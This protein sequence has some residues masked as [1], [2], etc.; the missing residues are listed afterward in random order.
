MKNIVIL[1]LLLSGMSLTAQQKTEGY[2][3]Y[4][5]KEC[6]PSI[7]RFFSQIEHKDSLWYRKDYFIREKKLQMQGAFH[8]KACKIGEGDFF[9]YHANGVL[10][11]TGKYVKGKKQGLWI[12][13]HPNKMMHDSIL[14]ENG[15]PIGTALSWHSNGYPEDSTVYGPEGMAT[16]VSWF[17]NGNVSSA[18]RLLNGKP[19]GTWQYFHSNGILS[20]KEVYEHG[21]L[22]A[23]NYFLEDGKAKNDTSSIDREAAFPGGL[24]GWAKYLSDH[25]DFPEGYK[26]THGDKAIVV[27]DATIGEDGTVNDVTVSV[28]FY[29]AFDRMAEIAMKKSPKWMPAID[30]NRKVK[31]YI[32]QPVIFSQP[33]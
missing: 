26:I 5:W 23:R 2:Y 18:G 6:E 1:C 12:S 28:P 16:R 10:E 20:A 24:D 14:Y 25:L 3:D 22:V 31:A 29:P 30:H 9:Y 32:R 17:D 4:D 8:D 33:D 21:K 15:N 13:L 27:I 19:H 7:A 11:Q